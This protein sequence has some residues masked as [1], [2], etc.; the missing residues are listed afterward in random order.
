MIYLIEISNPNDN[1]I[2]KKY[3]EKIGRSMPLAEEITKIRHQTIVTNNPLIIVS[4]AGITSKCFRKNIQELG[5]NINIH[6]CIQK[7]V[8]LI[9]TNITHSFLPLNRSI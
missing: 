3:Q 9:A 2:T 7:S 5:L 8:L 4:V 1:S 6:T